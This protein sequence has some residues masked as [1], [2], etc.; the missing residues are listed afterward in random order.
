MTTITIVLE[1]CRACAWNAGVNG[2]FTADLRAH[3]AV[4]PN[5]GGGSPRG[6][7]EISG[8]PQRFVW[9][10]EGLLPETKQLLNST[11]KKK[12][13]SAAKTTEEEPRAESVQPVSIHLNFKR[14]VFDPHKKMVQ[15]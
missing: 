14:Y 11:S 5:L 6:A 10:E 7:P 15:S 4:I 1:S 9:S 13:K 3:A 8:A 2:L 12:G